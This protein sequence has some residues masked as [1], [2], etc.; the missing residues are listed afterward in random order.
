MAGDHPPPADQPPHAAGAD[1]AGAEA[2]RDPPG[3]VIPG[4]SPAEAAGDWLAAEVAVAMRRIRDLRAE[5]GQ[6][7][8]R[9]TAVDEQVR[10]TGARHAHLAAAV[11]ED[12]APR[13][14]ALQQLVTE[15]LGQ[16][17]GDVDTLLADR[18]SED[19]TKN[20]P[21]DWTALTGR[22][23][24]CCS[25]ATWAAPSSSTT[26]CSTPRQ[27][28]S[29]SV[30]SSSPIWTPWPRASRRWERSPPAMSSA[31]WAESSSVTSGTRR[32]QVHA[33]DYDDHHGHRHLRDRTAPHLRHHRLLAPILLI[34]LRLTKDSPSAANGAAPR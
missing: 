16:L 19:N 2:V 27:R 24:V 3:R 23:A 1:Q 26:S 12:L 8:E 29:S 25:P 33:A 31:P 13:V 22:C 5:T 11:S 14:G 6:L 9:L 17:R 28:P 34:L 4:E 21:V 30:R 10:L 20:P 32:P 15:E 7:H 18:R